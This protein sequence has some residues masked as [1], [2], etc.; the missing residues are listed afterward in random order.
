MY[1]I[2]FVL[3]QFILIVRRFPYLLYRLLSTIHVR[4]V[5]KVRMLKEIQPNGPAIITEF[6]LEWFDNW[7][8]AHHEHNGKDVASHVHTAFNEF[9][10]RFFCLR[11]TEAK[12]KNHFN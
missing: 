11:P 8:E 2:L 5:E 1:A 6:W 3:V 10:A 7:R 9:H 4:V 12:E